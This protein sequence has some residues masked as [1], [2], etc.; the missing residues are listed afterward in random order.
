MLINFVPFVL[1]ILS[2]IICHVSRCAHRNRLNLIWQHIVCYTLLHKKIKKST[3]ACVFW[4]GIKRWFSVRVTDAVELPPA[5]DPLWQEL[6]DFLQ[7][8]KKIQI[9]RKILL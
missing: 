8:T 5:L 2:L 6:E 1:L 9:M 3:V 4:K 7:N